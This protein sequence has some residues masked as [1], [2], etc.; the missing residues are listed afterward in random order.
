MQKILYDAMFSKIQKEIIANKEEIEKLEKID[1]KYCKIEINIEKL[2]K[3]IE[4]YKIK[5]IKN[6]NKKILIYCNG[7]PY[8]VLNIA[9]IAITNNL[10]IKINIDDTMLGVNK[11][12]LEIINRT[13]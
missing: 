6:E 11:Y 4:Y 3:I 9:M 12:L 7:N 2:I 5:E 10:S 13:L 8:I 1:S